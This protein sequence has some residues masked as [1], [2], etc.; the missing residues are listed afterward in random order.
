MG[1]LYAR[2]EARDPATDA[3]H[4]AIAEYERMRAEPSTEPADLERLVNT[5]VLLFRQRVRPRAWA[6]GDEPLQRALRLLEP[7]AAGN[8]GR[9]KMLAILEDKLGYGTANAGDIRAVERMRGAASFIS[10]PS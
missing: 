6:D 3:F 8:A 7:V 1:R 2:I 4:K 9:L 10:T 5:L